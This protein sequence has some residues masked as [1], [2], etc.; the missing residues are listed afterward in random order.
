MIGLIYKSGIAALELRVLKR[1]WRCENCKRWK[2]HDEELPA[3]QLKCCMIY[4]IAESA[5]R[6]RHKK[7][8]AVVRGVVNYCEECK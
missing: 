5:R 7:K 1:K 3:Q 2:Y 6:P 8:S 4:F